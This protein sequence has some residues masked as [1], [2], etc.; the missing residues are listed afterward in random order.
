MRFSTL[1]LGALA[2]CLPAAAAPQTFGTDFSADYSLLDLGGPP[3]VP[4]PLGG[5]VFDRSDPDFLLIGGN[6]NNA[7]GAIYRIGVLRDASGRITGFDGAATLFADAPQ[8]DGGLTYNEDGVLFACGYPT[9]TLMQFR[10]GSTAPDRTDALSPLGVNNSVGACQFVPAGFPGAGRFLLGS[11]NSSDWYEAPLT[12]DGAGTFEPGMATQLVNLGGGP[13]GIVFIESGNPAFGVQSALV[14]EYSA[15]A[16]RAYELD[17]AGNPDPTTRRDFLTGLSGAEGATI[18]PITGDFLFSTFGGGNRV[19]LVSGFDLPTIY[20]N[21]KANSLGCTPTITY[22][23]LPS[24]SAVVPFTVTGLGFLNGEFG[25]MVHS[26]SP[27]SMPFGGG[28]LC[29]S[30]G[31]FRQPVRL[32]GGAGAPGTSCNGDYIDVL[33]GGWMNA[34]GYVVGTTVFVQ[35]LARDRG[36]AGAN[37][38]S[39]SDALRFT[40]QP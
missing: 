10:P 40:I 23:G 15:G 20:C 24:L 11:F 22:S 38:L 29:V 36:F 37:A 13:E 18:D 12:P 30:G 16:V 39:L 25:V 8:I 21:G 33:D 26:T 6:A 27:G 28:T 31:A 17:A 4:G 7:A 32:S 9:N 35:Y 5:L 14:S 34:S 1:P 2:L 19:V 3:M